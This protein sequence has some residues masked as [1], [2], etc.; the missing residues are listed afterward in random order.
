MNIDKN[1]V[2]MIANNSSSGYEFL[3]DLYIK[4]VIENIKTNYNLENYKLIINLLAKILNEKNSDILED[5][6][7]NPPVFSMPSYKKYLRFKGQ[8]EFEKYKEKNNIIYDNLFTR[9]C[10][11][12]KTESVFKTSQVF[13]L[14]IK[15]IEEVLGID[16]EKILHLFENYKYGYQ[17]NN[18]EIQAKSA[19]GINTIIKAFNSK[20]KEK[21]I[22]KY[23]QL[24][25]DKTSINFKNNTNTLLFDSDNFSDFLFSGDLGSKFRLFIKDKFNL[26]VSDDDLCK[27][28]S[29]ILSGK[30]NENL[31]FF[32]IDLPDDKNL[33]KKSKSYK[34]LRDNYLSKIRREFLFD[35]ISYM[36]QYMYSTKS[37]RQKLKNYFS[38]KQLRLLDEI[39]DIFNEAGAYFIISN[40]ELIALSQYKLP[41]YLE[42]KKIKAANKKY[43]MYNSF[44]NLVFKNFYAEKKNNS[45]FE[46]L[47]DFSAIC[48]LM[49]NVSDKTFDT[50]DCNSQR[51]NNLKNLLFD[52][53]LISLII[54]S[55]DNLDFVDKIIN[56]NSVISSFDINNL[57][58]IEKDINVF[59]YVDD[60]TF[61]LLGF[62]VSKKIV[63]N[64]QFL[65][66]DNSF[67]NIN[68]R[69][70]KADD[71][72]YRSEFVKTSSIPYFDPIK[73]NDL[74]LE[75]YN[76]NDPSILT[77]GIDSNTCF[78][79]SAV[80]NDYLFYSILNKNGMVVKI[81]DKDGMVARITCHRFFNVLMI[82]SIRSVTN[83]Y[84]VLS[85]DDVKRNDDI[86]KIVEM[87]ADKMIN[88][89]S[90]DDCPIDFVV[91][92]KAGVLKLDKYNKNYKVIPDIL[93]R[94]PIDV[95]SSDFD[96]FKNMYNDSEQFLQ[97]VPNF[98]GSDHPFITD[99]GNYPIL[100]LKSRDNKKLDR[101]VD[102]NFQ[103]PVD[104]YV[105]NDKVLYIGTGNILLT[106][107]EIK[108]INRIDA[109]SY[110]S[111]GFDVSLYQLPLYEGK[112]FT[113]Y[114]ITNSYYMLIDSDGN[115]YENAIIDKEYKKVF[116]KKKDKLS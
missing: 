92:N 98:D 87:F 31:E 104:K 108:Q 32:D 20:S 40:Y 64:R 63:Y 46:Y 94:M 109:I 66:D 6:F 34:R 1:R 3:N 15:K 5:L 68:L 99:Y 24:G 18:K 83:S 97:S 88:D 55:S 75:R 112:K 11:Y 61:A 58:N 52:N 110:I 41:S 79:L 60:M 51:Y 59:D 116:C 21:F 8:K 50:L 65:Y 17:H 115:I 56:N 25:V 4:D 2:E 95:Y 96:E 36:N 7:E 43:D 71:L 30:Q 39:R 48:Y 27:I 19:S 67:D 82:N 28:V 78:K 77:S 38:K 73:Y 54:F 35:D 10:N 107:D 85:I 72:M 57:V 70:R 44:C 81:S 114:V 26:D 22:Q 86:V 9:I 76:N 45:F 103:S 74:V 16:K 14:Q 12:L 13:D 37:Q 47:I 106:E 69:L 100:L 105:R 53:G 80:E 42:E 84:E 90:M 23:V 49:E 101:R 33:L 29:N 93:F 62:D 113:N 102:F 91:C 111:N 89:T